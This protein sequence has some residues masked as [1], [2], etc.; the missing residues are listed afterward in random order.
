MA[1]D[2]RIR[3]RVVIEGVTTPS[4]EAL[5]DESTGQP[6]H[7]YGRVTILA[8][9]VEDDALESAPPELPEA[10]DNLTGLEQLGLDALM[11][12]ETAGYRGAKSTRR[13]D[14]GAQ[15]RPLP[16][17]RRQVDDRLGRVGRR[18]HRQDH[19]RNRDRSGHRAWS[20]SRR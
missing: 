3:E 8:E 10:P 7:R 19:R 14:G 15:A 9:P 13:R 6:I 11:L 2:L 18:H 16:H 17:C 12:R 20:D 4:L 1:G 5:S